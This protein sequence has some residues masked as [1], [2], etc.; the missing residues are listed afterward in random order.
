MYL[1]QLDW[2]DLDFQNQENG[3]MSLDGVCS[4]SMGLS[5]YRD[6]TGTIFFYCSQLYPQL[7]HSS[8]REVVEKQKNMFA[9]FE[10][11]DY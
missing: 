9:Q 10:T 3:L 7:R 2:L 6:K 4:I 8:G 1:F 11:A 5:S